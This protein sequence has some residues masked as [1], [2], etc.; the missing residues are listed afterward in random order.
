MMNGHEVERALTGACV[1]V[2]F[3]AVLFIAIQILGC[4]PAKQPGDLP[5]YC[6]SEELYTAE[7]V[8]C[9]DRAETLAQ[10]QM[11]RQAVDHS[12]GIRQTTRSK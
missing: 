2:F 12:C 11:C 3:G 4:T 8:R 6:Y 5:K 9:V 10:S 1:V 7:L